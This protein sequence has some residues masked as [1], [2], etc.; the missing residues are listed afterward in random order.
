MENKLAVP[1]GVPLEG[2]SLHNALQRCPHLPPLGALVLPWCTPA[3]G[4]RRCSLRERSSSTA[5]VGC[6]T[7]GWT[8]LPGIAPWDSS[9]QTR[10]GSGCEA[11]GAM[12]ACSFRTVT[13]SRTGSTAPA[14]KRGVATSDASERAPGACVSSGGRELGTPAGTAG[15]SSGDDPAE[16][17]KFQTIGI[18]TKIEI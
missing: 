17:L 8:P 7:A 16:F 5:S 15:A 9:P 2:V 18:S 4:W 14:P 12:P 1:Y 6:C 13:R 10:C 3:G 11:R